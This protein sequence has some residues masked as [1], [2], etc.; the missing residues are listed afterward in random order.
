VTKKKAAK[1]KVTKKKV[2]KKKVA[3]KASARP[4]AAAAAKVRRP[5]HRAL[6]VVES[7]TKAKTIKKYLGPNFVVK[8]SVGHV[9][10]L[11]KSQMAV[12]IEHDFTPRYETI[13]GKSK[14]LKEIKD[15]AK[16]VDVI[17]LAPDPDREGEA[18][19]YHLAQELGARHAGHTH[20]I[21]FNEI[22]RAAVLKA[23]DDP[24]PINHLR[25]QSQQARRILDRIVGYQI[26]PIL[27]EKVR[28]GLSAGRVQSVAVRLIVEREALIRAFVPEEYWTVA[29]ELSRGEPPSFNARV[30]RLGDDKFEP[31]D[32]ATAHGARAA[33]ESEPVVV[34][35]VSRKER[36]R[37]PQAPLITSKLQQEAAGRLRFTAKRTMMVAQQLYEGVELG[38]EGQVALITYMRTDSTRV[39]EGAMAEARSFI[40]TTFGPDYVPAEPPSYRSKKG[41]QDAHEAIRP[42][43]LAYPP[44]RVRPYL[45]V[46]QDRLYTLVWRF[47]LASQMSQAVYD[48]TGVDLSCGPYGLRASGSIITFKGFLAAHEA[49]GPVEAPKEAEAGAEEEESNILPPLTEGQAVQLVAAQATQH[50]T[51]PPPRFSESTL[52]RE[53]EES[54]I[55]RPSTYATI[56]STIVTRDYVEKLPSGR[57]V[58]TELGTLITELLCA[59]F[60][61][62]LDVAFTAEMERQLDDVETGEV[63]WV[64]LLKGF[65]HGGFEK[66]LEAA[67]TSMRDVK[68]EEI[69]T[70]HRCQLCGEPM[71]IKW[72]RNG[73]FLAC[74]GYPGCR[75]TRDYKRTLE[76]DIELLP[77]VKTDARCPICQGPMVVKRGRFGQFIACE[78]YP[79]CKGTRPLSIGVDCPKGCGNYLSERRSKQ[80]RVFYG[81]SGYPD[82]TFAAWDRPVPGPCPE[83]QSPYL[84]RKYSKKDGVVIKCPTKGCTYSRDPELDDADARAVAG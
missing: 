26:S 43:S 76:G 1:K 35:K 54:G 67:R 2:A 83:C 71:L 68:R 33:L 4:A 59:A 25:Y 46:E 62:V 42:T 81:C 49:F 20:R 29:A 17:Y 53:L 19:A 15:A 14:V 34:Q 23:I 61:Q 77:E 65:Y 18:I 82:C 11:P 63:D 72:G 74:K 9:K 57:F 21:T 73:S 78:G 58:P 41:A 56:M 75:N 50:F 5:G 79:E 22:T 30:V 27:W 55:G 37:K 70:E 69:P 52:V 48:Q 13:R 6:V 16:D 40:G 32:E 39:S 38:D 64:A 66:S 31:K 12:D 47:F 45:T 3:K 80:G 44:E 28:R 10:D 8:A 24:H 36:R 51:Q 7:P 60:P 84:V